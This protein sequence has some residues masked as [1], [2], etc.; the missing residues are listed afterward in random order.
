MI[1]EPFAINTDCWDGVPTAE[2]PLY[3]PKGTKQLYKATEGWSVFKNIIEKDDAFFVDNAV[4]I[5]DT[6][7]RQGRKMTLSLKMKNTAAIRGFQFDLYLPEGVTVAKS[8]KGKIL[9]AL[10]EGRLPDEDEHSLTFSEQA[11]GAIRF[12]C[13]SQYDETFTGNN[14]EIAT[15]QL[16]V[17]EDVAEGDYEIQLKNMTLTES[18]IEKHYDTALLR[19]KLTIKSYVVGDVTGEGNVNAADVTALANYIVGNGTL[20]NEAAADV[21]DDTKIDI[22]DVTALIEIIKKM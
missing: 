10:S 8:S 12:L 6:L 13:S 17:A 5:N 7:A 22:Q 14:G 19:S 21:N 16:N 4:Y 9:G 15:L 1:R 2:I 18:D 3:V 20:A 11:D